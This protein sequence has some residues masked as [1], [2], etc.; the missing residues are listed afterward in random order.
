MAKATHIQSSIQIQQLL[1]QLEAILQN[2]NGTC[3]LCEA[4]RLRALLM[5]NKK[6]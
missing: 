1:K 6:A 2:Q 5:T 3:P 4:N